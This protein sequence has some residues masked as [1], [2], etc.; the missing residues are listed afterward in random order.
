MALTFTASDKIGDIVAKLPK[1]SE[2][3]KK[4]RIDFC[5]GGGK[6]VSEAARENGLNEREIVDDLNRL[7]ADVL[8]SSQEYTSWVNAPYD[9][10]V[11]HIVNTHHAYLYTHFAPIGE[12]VTKI[13]RVHGAHHPELA[14][15]HKLYHNLKTELEQH[16]IQEETVTFPL[17]KD[18]AA[19]PSPELAKQALDTVG[20][21]EN[22]HDEAGQLLKKLRKVTNDFTT[23]PD[24]CTTYQA[25]YRMLE[26][27]ES[28]IFEH[29]SLENN[30]LF[31]RLAQEV[32]HE[33]EHEH[34]H[35][36]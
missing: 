4:Y 10:L 30:I 8:A 28:D 12:Y 1:A 31:P 20:D 33:H 16:M 22:D 24:G 19:N 5:C 21:L 35:H 25:T 17:I 27:M 23:P 15:V 13:L 36:H 34:E 32:G 7:A 18:F 26:E 2:V 3:F 9:K 29:I 14:E 11:D 6:L